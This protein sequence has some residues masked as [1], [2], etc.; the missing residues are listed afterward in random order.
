MIQIGS[1]A[2]INDI[3][4][5]NADNTCARIVRYLN[6]EVHAQALILTNSWEK[7]GIR[8]E[9]LYSRAGVATQILVSVDDS[10]FLVD[11]G[12]GTLRDLLGTEIDLRESIK[13]VFITHEHFDHV[14]GLFSLLNYMHIIGRT[15]PISI[16]VP[17]DNLIARTF[18]EIQKKYSVRYRGFEVSFPIEIIGISA[19][20]EKFLDPIFVKAFAVVHRGGTGLN[21]IGLFSPAVGY[22]MKYG[23]VRIVFSGDTSVCDSLRREVENADLAVLDATSTEKSMIQEKH[24]IVKEAEEIGSLAKKF[25]LIHKR[26]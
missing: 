10:N 11:V 9:V 14:G 21:P 8:V 19:Q 12:D 7:N 24:M 17:Q 2:V 13:A 20:E 23:N 26:L 1:L 6:N 16:V 5:N 15:K 4:F 25:L 22:V 3:K 18:V